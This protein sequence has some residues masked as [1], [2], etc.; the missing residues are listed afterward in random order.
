MHI[1]FIHILERIYDP[2][3]KISDSFGTQLFTLTAGHLAIIFNSESV[4]LVPLLQV[5]KALR[6]DQ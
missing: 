2:V 6:G 5:R 1:G 4:K 3:S